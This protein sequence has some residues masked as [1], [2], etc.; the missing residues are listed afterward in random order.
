M[1]ETNFH[2]FKI[3]KAR[4]W[5]YHKLTSIPQEVNDWVR[6]IMYRVSYLV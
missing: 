2:D 4:K 5:S 3:L 6:F 1:R